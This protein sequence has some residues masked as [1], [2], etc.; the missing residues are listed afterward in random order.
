MGYVPFLMDSLDDIK[1]NMAKDKFV[2]P[3]GF[4]HGVVM[5]ISDAEYETI[6][7]LN[8]KFSFQ[9]IVPDV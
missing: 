1:L 2:F 3:Y 4:K 6:K 8:D 7:N 9:K 5:E